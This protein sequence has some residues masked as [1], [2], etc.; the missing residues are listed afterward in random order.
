MGKWAS[1]GTTTDA[2]WTSPSN[3]RKS[4]VPRAPCIEASAS[5]RPSS[6]STTATSS[7]S[8]SAAYFSA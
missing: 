2:I 4:V 5:A 3:S 1:V 7:T 8:G 6:T